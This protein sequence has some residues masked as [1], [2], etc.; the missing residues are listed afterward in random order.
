MF[1][2]FHYSSVLNIISTLFCFSISTAGESMKQHALA[3][4]IHSLRALRLFH[5]YRKDEL[6]IFII[7]INDHYYSSFLVSNF[8]SLIPL[9]LHLEQNNICI[10]PCYTAILNIRIVFLVLP[11]FPKSFV[12]STFFSSQMTEEFENNR[13]PYLL[14][15]VNPL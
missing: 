6:E 11:Q 3:A 13:N 9:E 5:L 15:S 2:K 14:F 12:F 7:I 10:H 4:G 8:S 1:L